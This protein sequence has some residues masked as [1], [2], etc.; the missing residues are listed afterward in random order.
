MF[1]SGLW[2]KRILRRWVRKEQ[3]QAMLMALLVLTLGSVLITPVLSYASTGGKAAVINQRY[4]AELYAADAGVEYAM[5]HILNGLPVS[6]P[7]NVGNLS[8]TITVSQ[9]SEL[10]YGP[11]ITDAGPQTWRL[12][13]S[14]SMVDIG[15]GIST[16]TITVTNQGPSTIHLVEIGAGLPEGFTYMAGSTSGDITTDNPSF[17]NSDRLYWTLNSTK[18]DSGTSV[19]HV[20]RIQGSGTTQGSY[21]WVKANAE[22]IGT[23]SSCYGYKVVSVA[24]GGTT[25]QAHVVKNG[26]SIYP[27]SWE[28]N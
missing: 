2:V 16:F 11:V 12:Q 13:V 8:V 5:W 22:S 4:T 14:S 23:V 10:P 3:G 27:V 19:H 6:S 18:L 15:G 17:I 21:S 20:F 26:G 7:I 24:N 1:C 25:I 9:L 28:V